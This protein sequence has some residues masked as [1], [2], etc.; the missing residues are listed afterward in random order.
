MLPQDCILLLE[1]V[2]AAS[3]NRDAEIDS[4][5]IATSSS[6]QARKSALGNVS[7]STLLNS[8]DGVASQ[9]G[10]VLI[11]T[12]N[13]IKRLDEALIRP[14]RVD[15]KV[16]LGLADR[17]M[18]ADLFCLVFKPKKGDATLS[19]DAQLGESQREDEKRVERLA[20]TFAAKVPELKFSPAEIFSFLVEQRESPGEAI[21]NVEQ[22]I[23]TPVRPKSEPPITTEGAKLEDTRLVCIQRRVNNT[24]LTIQS[25]GM[26]NR[27]VG[28]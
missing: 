21:H 24:S 4:R 1:D 5:R 6:P 16:E 18:A 10:R 26:M 17:K 14:R 11:M 23:S 15:K 28:G 19:K 13:H 20:E 25:G 2:D 3:S 22:L 7:L 27:G 9:E 8:I 12:T